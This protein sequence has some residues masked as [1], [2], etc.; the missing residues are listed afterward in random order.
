MIKIV[1]Y[2]LMGDLGV[3]EYIYSNLWCFIGGDP[4][5]R[6]HPGPLAFG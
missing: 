1:I 2:Q 4:Y 5:L 3:Y 6:F